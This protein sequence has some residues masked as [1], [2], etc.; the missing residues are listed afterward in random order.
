MPERGMMRGHRQ[1]VRGRD[2]ERDGVA[3]DRVDVPV[4]RDVLGLAVVGAEGHPVRPELR[5]ERDQ[6]AQV[7]RGGRLADEEPE[8][9]SEALAALLDGERLVVGADPCGGVRLQRVPA[10]ARRVPV[11]PLRTVDGELRELCRIAADDAGEVH[12]LRQ[13]DH[14]PAAQEA[15]EIPG[16]ERPVRRL[17]LRRGHARRGGEEHLERQVLAH[18]DEP[19]DAVGAE[20]V[21][22]LVRVGDDGGR[23]EREH[24]PRELRRQQLRRLEMEMRVDEAGRDVG[25]VGVDRLA[26]LVGADARDHPVA[27]RHVGLQPLAREDREHPAAADDEIGRS[28]PAGN[29]EPPG[30]ITLQRHVQASRTASIRQV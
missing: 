4:L 9:G 13:P 18:V 11:D 12:H 17:E 6:R 27:D 19:V 29:R 21:R 24:E 26:T 22:D 3:H 8:A 14:A 16:R 30:Q 15:L 20:H 23:A 10:N 7:A 2:A 28:I 25:A 5:D 1:R